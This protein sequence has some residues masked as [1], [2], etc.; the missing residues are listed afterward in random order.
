MSFEN[1]IQKIKIKH[2]I[3]VFRLICLF[4]QFLVSAMSITFLQHFHNKDKI[5]RCLVLIWPYYW[6]YYYFFITNNLP[7]R[8]CCE[9]D[10]EKLWKCCNY[11]I[12]CN[13]LVQPSVE[14]NF[15]EAKFFFRVFK[16]FLRVVKTHF[17]FKFNF[18]KVYV[19]K[20]HLRMVK[21]TTFS[22]TWHHPYFQVG[23]YSQH[24]MKMMA[25][26]LI[27]MTKE[28]RNC[29]NSLIMS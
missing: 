23:D 17:N 29:T 12:S 14:Q 21:V 28:K 9:I 3:W 1:K 10:V 15:G 6:N 24:I 20:I 4:R 7:L 19:Y 16:L 11:K 2:F 8:I 22:N 13:V 26:S 5:A 25:Y 27:G 18:L